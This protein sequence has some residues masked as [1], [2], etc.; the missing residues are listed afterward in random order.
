MKDNFHAFIICGGAV[1]ERSKTL[2]D[3]VSDWHVDFSDQI[4]IDNGQESIGIED[5]RNFWRS[6]NFYPRQS[7]YTVGIIRNAHYLTIQAQHA[8][9]KTLEE[10]PSHARII[11]ELAINDVLLPTILSR[12][13]IISL[14]NT[15]HML[16][17][18]YQDIDQEI[19]T[20]IT[21]TPGKQLASIDT[22]ALSK[23]MAIDWVQSALISCRK[24]MRDDLLV[25]NASRIETLVS[26]CHRLLS[27]LGK[28]H[29]NVSPKLVL[30]TTFLPGKARAP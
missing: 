26:Y 22:I 27:S 9:L 5:I 25:Q 11:L 20:L 13:V 17:E 6:L 24:R 29:V 28:L 14:Q 3:Y 7:P 21:N 12:C 19:L 18:G 30:D 10:P 15:N 16:S 23:E 1:S 4:I 2:S 8:L